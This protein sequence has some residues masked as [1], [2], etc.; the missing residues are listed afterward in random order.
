MS[1]P[2]IEVVVDLKVTVLPDAPLIAETDPAPHTCHA[3][4]WRRLVAVCIDLVIFIPIL[5]FLLY[6]VYGASYFDEML[7]AAVR[8]RQGE[9]GN[10]DL[11]AIHGIGDAIITNLLPVLLVVYFWMRHLGTPGKL[12]L[13]CHI[14]DA[15]SGAPLSLKQSL[16]RNLGYVFSLLAFG[17]GFLWIAWDV[18]KQGLHDKIARSVVIRR[19]CSQ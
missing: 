15:N 10:N 7:G 2:P 9:S 17:L 6:L 4:F 18:R 16:L 13:G 19:Q 12:L 8:L 1:L 5:G 3:G 14:V 11:L